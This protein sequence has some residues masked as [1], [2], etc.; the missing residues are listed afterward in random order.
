MLDVE[1]SQE[2]KV[3]GKVLISGIIKEEVGLVEYNTS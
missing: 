3:E 2:R 1:K